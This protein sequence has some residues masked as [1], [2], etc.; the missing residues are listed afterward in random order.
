M[1]KIVVFS[2]VALVLMGVR[3]LAA[4]HT[5]IRPSFLLTAANVAKVRR[6][7]QSDPEAAARWAE[8]KAEADALLGR[9][10]RPLEE[11]HYQGMLDTDP[12]R[13]RS[14]Q[15]LDDMDAVA[16]LG[17]AFVASGDDRYANQARRYILAWSS[18]Y[19]PT[20]NTIHENKL[21]PIY[22][23]Y[24]VLRDRFS[25]AQREQVE[26]WMRRIAE[27]EIETGHKTAAPG[28]PKA[29]WHAK[30]LK[31]VGL[32][33]W[34]TGH[35]ESVAYALEGVRL[36]AQDGL[37]PDGTSVDL[38]ERDA[39]SYHVSGLASLLAVAVEAARRGEKVGGV[40]LYHYRAPSGASL[41]QSVE[42]VRPYATGE[43]QR[44]EWKHTKSGLD[45][46]RAEAGIAY[47][48]PGKL[49]DPRGARELMELAAFFDPDA[50]RVVGIIEK[51]AAKKYPTW[52]LVL[53]DALR[54]AGAGLGLPR[55]FPP[56]MPR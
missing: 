2:A 34:I 14:E 3:P 43:K 56:K 27:R 54:P 18:T 6:L 20:G 8:L 23:Y 33:G 55:T 7:V 39:L 37:R 45:R 31:I 42:F 32:V 44:P 52:Q 17:H 28:R 48:Q 36:Y 41:R 11:I 51:S 35:R 24:A 12:K 46:R 10:P 15:S 29:N 5:P 21:E 25:A 38:E 50:V 47:Y 30:R 53:I 9:S 16:C 19:R 26:G 13:Q 4:E 22:V 1:R 40:D 49:Y